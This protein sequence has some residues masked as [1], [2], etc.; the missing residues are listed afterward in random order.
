MLRV[1]ASLLAIVMRHYRILSESSPGT[2]L[3]V[4]YFSALS[5][6]RH[7]FWKKNF[8]NKKAF[9]YFLSN[10]ARNIYHSEKN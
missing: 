8:L 1:G 6:K 4:L 9:F 3:D 7:D 2:Y 10:F 5:H